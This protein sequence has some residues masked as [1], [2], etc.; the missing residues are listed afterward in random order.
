MLY[1]IEAI[2]I[3]VVC[4][5]VGF[6]AFSNYKKNVET[7]IG[8]AQDKAREI[9]D[10]ALKTAETKKREG[11]LEVKEESIR[12][13]NELDKEI[14]E[15]RSEIQKNERRIVQ[16]EENLD[17]KLEVSLS[18]VMDQAFAAS[19]TDFAFEKK[20]REEGM[21]FICECKKASPS[22][23]LICEDFDYLQIA[24][25]YEKAGASA[26]SVLTTR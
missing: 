24:K 9:I 22:K 26:I 19:R 16:K 3:I 7:T 15:R 12:T 5:L 25:D 8:N 1:V 17:K 20:L 6:V 10:E 14:K 2:I 23:G 13:K 18:K 4:A 21:S 11:L